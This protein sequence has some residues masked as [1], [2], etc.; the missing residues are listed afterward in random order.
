[1]DL[2]PIHS[3]GNWCAKR[4][5]MACWVD[6]DHPSGSKVRQYL[7]MA[8]ESP[9]APMI[10]GCASHSAM[11]IYV[12]SAAKLTATKAHIFVPQRKQPTDATWYAIKMD[13]DIE[14][15]YIRPAHMAVLR[16]R[17][18]DLGKTL[19]K[20]VRWSPHL[21]LMDTAEQA[22]NIPPWVKRVVVPTGSGLTAAGVLAGLAKRKKPPHILAVAVSAMAH[23]SSIMKLAWKLI[24][25]PTGPLFAAALPSLQLIKADGDYGDALA[26]HLPDGTPLDPFYAAKAMRYVVKGDCLWIPGLRPVKAFPQGIQHMFRNWKGFK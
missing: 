12:A 4:E 3:F 5:D 26:H 13:A 24:E 7:Q 25:S 9:G 22:Q 20:T 19:G 15:H 1:M 17:A 11:Q 6:L 18:R 8:Q 23:E 14:M 2:T 16:K 21:A 10:V